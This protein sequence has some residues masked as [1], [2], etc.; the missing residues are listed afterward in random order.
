MGIL[1][2]TATLLTTRIAVEMTGPISVVLL[3]AA[4]MTFACMCAS[5]HQVCLSFSL[6]CNFVFLNCRA[7][8]EQ[9]LI[10]W[11]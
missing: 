4:G 8:H 1:S 9:C 10:Q 5:T 7:S 11:F 2:R 3:L 6:R